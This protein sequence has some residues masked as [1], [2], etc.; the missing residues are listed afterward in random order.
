M[1]TRGAFDPK[2]QFAITIVLAALVVS[3][4]HIAI[5]PYVEPPS[6]RLD[7]KLLPVAFLLGAAV[8][9]RV[10]IWRL[11]ALR[12][13]MPDVENKFFLTQSSVIGRFR[14]GS[15]AITLQRSGIGCAYVVWFWLT[16]LPH[17]SIVLFGS[18]GSY[19]LG[20][21]LTGQTLPFMRLW[22]EQR[23]AAQPSA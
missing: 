18:L 1:S 15:N 8:G 4:A 3:L 22:I 21:F 13:A 6:W 14:E 19:V 20:Q 2:V 9:F 17:G 23:K 7:L 5:N 11:Q 10:G 12:K 16:A